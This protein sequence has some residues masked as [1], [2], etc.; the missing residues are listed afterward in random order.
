MGQGKKPPRPRPGQKIPT[1][2]ARKNPPSPAHARI[3]LSFEYYEVGNIYVGTKD[4][5]AG[6][7]TSSLTT[8]QRPASS[9]S[10][11]ATLKPARSTSLMADP[12]ASASDA[13]TRSKTTKTDPFRL[14]ARVSS[15][16]MPASKRASEISGVRTSTPASVTVNSKTFSAAVAIFGISEWGQLSISGR[17]RRA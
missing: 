7:I 5:P 15:P 13:D 10:T 8:T 12:T 17:R 6:K 9:T 1:E 14:P 2:D 16:L 3:R 4:G 11:R